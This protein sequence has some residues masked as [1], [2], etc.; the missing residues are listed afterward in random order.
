MADLQRYR[1]VRDGRFGPGCVREDL[2][3]LVSW[4]LEGDGT[5]EA[6][7]PFA[8]PHLELVR[9]CRRAIE[10]AE[11][12]VPCPRTR[13]EYGDGLIKLIDKAE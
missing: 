7:F 3:A 10:L 9:R 6:P 2:S 8:L 12:W 13:P 4:V 11:R 5:K 1:T